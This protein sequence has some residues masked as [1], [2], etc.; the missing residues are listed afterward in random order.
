[1]VRADSGPPIYEISIRISGKDYVIKLNADD[2]TIT[3]IKE[4]FK[5]QFEIDLE[6]K[7]LL[8]SGRDVTD[9]LLKHA[10]YPL[11]IFAFKKK[12]S[13][14]AVKEGIDIPSPPAG[15]K[16]IDIPIKSIEFYIRTPE[17][18]LFVIKIPTSI[19]KDKIIGK[20]KSELETKTGIKPEYQTLIS[21]G[22]VF[23]D[24]PPKWLS[25][26]DEIYL[27]LRITN[28]HYINE[29]VEE[30]TNELISY[31]SVPEDKVT[32]M[33]Q[34]KWGTLSE[35]EYKRHIKC[36]KDTINNMIISRKP[37]NLYLSIGSNCIN[38]EGTSYNMTNC[39]KNQ[40]TPPIDFHK[41]T[42]HTNELRIIILDYFRSSTQIEQLKELL[43]PKYKD[44]TIICNMY[45][46]DKF[47]PLTQQL[48]NF[49]KYNKL[50]GGKTLCV[51]YAKYGPGKERAQFSNLIE[52][53]YPKKI[54]IAGRRKFPTDILQYIQ[55]SR[56]MY[57]DWTYYN[58]VGS[59]GDSDASLIFPLA[60]SSLWIT[61]LPSRGV[62]LDKVSELNSI[63][64]D[65]KNV[66]F[67]SHKID[68]DI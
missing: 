21:A 24:M 9:D 26:D 19:C 14:P 28:E 4:K 33:M 42:D 49:L 66:Y 5:E 27:K 22:K 46:L 3:K 25:T 40:N 10:E 47:E 60:N 51:N 15:K 53:F 55:D 34:H 29:L 32:D 63:E 8:S 56:S 2:N 37:Y 38:L 31:S 35:Y 57:L 18:E 50:K 23:D 1:M 30:A 64:E 58:S 62:K 44:N 16:G 68:L 7:R 11:D 12:N 13:P 67:S 45:W 17:D 59:G 48:K 20:I 39:I 43:K 61:H 65:I 36:F 54:E 41:D 6:D 52:L